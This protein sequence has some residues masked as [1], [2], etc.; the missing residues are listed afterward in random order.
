[1]PQGAKYIRLTGYVSTG[2][3]TLYGFNSNSK[4][5][6]IDDLEKKV[7]DIINTAINYEEVKINQLE[8]RNYWLNSETLHW[9][10]STTYKHALL[11]L[12]DVYY[13]KV[14][15]N[16][17]NRAQL[18][19]LSNNNT[20]VAGELAPVGERGCER[21]PRNCGAGSLQRHRDARL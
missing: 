17:T 4:P 5:Q 10:N 11:D 16:N 7:D 13:I 9:G 19:F 3:A 18:A 12:K 21:R 2:N 14:K 8:Q 6:E 1:M 20:P 15:S